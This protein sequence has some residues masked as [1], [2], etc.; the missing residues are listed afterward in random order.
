MSHAAR[1][2]LTALT[3][4]P[5]V[6]AQSAHDHTA[7]PDPPSISTPDAD[8]A[9]HIPPEPPTHPMEPMSA[10]EMA[11][12]MEMDD[13][14][15][16]GAVVVDEFEWQDGN[17]ALAWEGAAWYG[18]D[19]GKLRLKTEGTYVEDSLLHA[20]TEAL[21]DHVI[22]PRW[23]LQAGLRLDS[24]VGPSRTW[25]AIGV[26]GLAPYW[27]DVEATLYVGDEGRT[28]ARLEGRYDL[29][30]TQQ[31]VLQ[32]QLE[33]NFQGKDDPDAGVG[34]GLTEMEAGLR[35]RYEIR[36]EFAPYAGIHW[37]R[38][39]GDTADYAEQAGNDVEDTQFVA[40]IRFWF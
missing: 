11:E 39:F 18:G 26:E 15:R 4:A 31:L 5:A 2:L 10:A 30:L 17:D 6:Q 3:T 32:P 8:P 19:S 20:R 14:A 40:G 25:A 36:R 23:N 37:V 38:R 21:W 7:H 29:L 9:R 13:A 16:Y 12:I 28:A 35:V 1:L 24:G 22:A 27:L 33:M 34:T